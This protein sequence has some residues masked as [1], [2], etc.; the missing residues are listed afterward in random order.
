MRLTP[1][2]AISRIV[3][4]AIVIASAAS[5]SSLAQTNVFKLEDIWST[6]IAGAPPPAPVGTWVKPDNGSGLVFDAM[7]VSAQGRIAFVG[8]EMTGTAR[9]Q[10]LLVDAEARASNRIVPIRSGSIRPDYLATLALGEGGEIW[11]GGFSDIKSWDKA[12]AYVASLAT[13]GS[14]LWEKTYRHGG[15]RITQGITPMATGDLILAGKDER[16]SWIARVTA[17]GR[18]IWNRPIGNNKGIAVAALSSNRIFAVGY[19]SFGS[20]RSND[21]KDDVVAW[22][23]DDSGRTI[24]RQV[25]REA[26]NKSEGGSFGDVAISTTKDAV[27]VLSSWNA[28]GD[29]KPVEITKLNLIGKIQWSISLPTTV[30]P[31]QHASTTRGTCSA[32]LTTAAD[33]SAIVACAVDGQIHIYRLN[34]ISGAYEESVLPLPECQARRISRLFLAAQHDGSMILSGSRPLSNVAPSCTWISRLVS[35]R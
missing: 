12:D 14:V 28:F 11:L 35:S 22:L 31:V 2:E 4:L 13:D 1:I 32:S 10:V 17:D 3:A 27:Y 19:D 30:G 16:T 24:D 20:F 6:S 33:G 21:F 29:S 5:P 25:L 34:S 23:I 26:I 15:R 9:R 7:A 8:T 18:E